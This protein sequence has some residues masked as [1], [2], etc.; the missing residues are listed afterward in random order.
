MPGTAFANVNHQAG[1]ADAQEFLRRGIACS[2]TGSESDDLISA[3]KWFNLAAMQGN[4]EA[5]QLR[6]EIADEMSEA[7]IAQ[8]QRAARHFLT[9][10]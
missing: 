5:A 4:S 9:R 3:H 6:R 7:E 8:A 10:H 2:V 1:R